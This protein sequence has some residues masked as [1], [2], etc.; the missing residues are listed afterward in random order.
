MVTWQEETLAVGYNQVYVLATGFP[1]RPTKASSMVSA[2]VP[3]FPEKDKTYT[4]RYD[5][6]LNLLYFRLEHVFRSTVRAST[7]FAAS[8]VRQI[9]KRAAHAYSSLAREKRQKHFTLSSWDVLLL[10][11]LL[12]AL[13]PIQ[14]AGS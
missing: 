1:P 11:R 9:M 4:M 12:Y 7:H 3:C 14:V 13:C 8:C 5:R 6:A 2:L 10:S